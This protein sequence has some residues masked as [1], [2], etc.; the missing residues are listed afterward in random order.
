MNEIERLRK[1]EAQ[2]KIDM[3]EGCRVRH[4]YLPK[5]NDTIDEALANFLNNYP[6]QDKI[7]ILFLR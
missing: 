5:Q 4:K 6:N 2:L 3:V 7:K 1:V